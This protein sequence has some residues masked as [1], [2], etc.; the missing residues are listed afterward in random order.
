MRLSNALVLM[1]PAPNQNSWPLPDLA[2]RAGR[3]SEAR[4]WIADDRRLGVMVRRLVHRSGSGLRDVAMDDPALEQ[5]WWAVEMQAGWPCRWTSGDAM[6]PL[7]SAG[8]LEVDVAGVSSYPLPA[9][10]SVENRHSIRV[11]A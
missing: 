7:L 5:G 6:L 10:L 9:A 2:S 11:A 3:P 4:P 1:R 8:V